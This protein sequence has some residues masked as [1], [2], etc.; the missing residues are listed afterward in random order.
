VTTLA[1]YQ[2]E[3]E[4]IRFS[5]D[6][7]GILLVTLHR[8]GGTLRWGRDSHLEV[9]RMLG[10]VAS[11]P[12]NRVVIITGTGEYFT[13]FELSSFGPPIGGT[14]YGHTA[15]SWDPVMSAEHSLMTGHLSIPVPVIAAVNGPAHVHA[16]IALL[17]DIVLATPDSHFADH[18]HFWLGVVPGDG[19]HVIWPALL[20]PNRGRYFL[21]AGSPIHAD[22]ALRLGL[23]GEII[24]PGSLLDRAY[25]HARKIAGYPSMNVRYTRDLLTRRL[26]QAMHEE[27][28]YGLALQGLSALAAAEA[29]RAAE[30]VGR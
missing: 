21:M 14:K 27:L 18:S 8:E 15:Q 29:N 30:E 4:C 1:Q 11:D 6:E 16:D 17:S 28:D 7:D 3:F 12:G 13:K 2:A 22:E 26:R 25:E 19:V 23:I 10:L 5:R 9:C 20:G 24:E